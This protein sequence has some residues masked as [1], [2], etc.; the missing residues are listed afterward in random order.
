MK[1][2]R[3]I[4]GGL[5]GLALGVSLRKLGVE[6]ELTEA[7]GYPRHKVCGEFIC[8]V[9]PAV[10]HGLGVREV[11]EK[12]IEHRTLAWWMEGEKV[13]EAELPAVAL[14]MSR[15]RL[16]YELAGL[17]VRAGGALETGR[18]ARPGSEG[19]GVVWATGKR[20][21]HGR[22]IGL[23][24]HALDA[25]VRGLE[26]HVGSR[27]YLGI[28]GVEGGRVNCCGLF[29]VDP[30][31]KGRG[32]RLLAAYLRANGLNRL[33]DRM[34]GWETDGPS[35]SATAGFSF[36]RQERVGGFCVGDAYYLIPPFTGNGMSMALE[37]AWLASEWLAGYARGDLGWS[38]ARA[39]YERACSGHF[40]KRT[41]L[42]GGLHPLL[43]HRLGRR[44]LRSA[45]SAG[46]LPFDYLFQQLRTP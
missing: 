28:C 34:G 29:R 40:R 8:G 9:E 31:I 44:L 46:V 35:F 19:E 13:L 23:K 39:G 32:G 41:K 7:G 1:K 42:S 12:S 26:M 3:I 33:A 27:G 30:G 45:A 16:D 36:G 2:I 37:S 11:V 4:G 22:W 38:D 24:I 43:F 17:F 21:K 5:A 10:L 6:T 25:P 18:R 14:G 15:H 20:R